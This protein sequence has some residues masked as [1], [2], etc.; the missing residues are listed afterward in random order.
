[1]NSFYMGAIFPDTLGHQLSRNGFV[2]SVYALYKNPSWR[3]GFWHDAEIF[4]KVL[5]PSD[6]LKKM[7][8][9]GGSAPG[10]LL[11]PYER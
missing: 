6:L 7:D 4:E 2:V 8:P 1:M 9:A 10:K 5:S 11:R 3:I